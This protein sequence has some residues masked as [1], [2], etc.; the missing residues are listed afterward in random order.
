MFSK[1]SECSNSLLNPDLAAKKRRFAASAAG[2]LV[3]RVMKFKLPLL[4]LTSFVLGGCAT[5]CHQ[6]EFYKPSVENLG[7]YSSSW[8]NNRIYVDV[9]DGF[10][11]STFEC[12]TA[13][14]RV[15]GSPAAICLEIY[16]DEGLVLEFDDRVA[17]L[18]NELG[19]KIG[20]GHI[21]KEI[22]FVGE[23]NRSR[24]F[25]ERTLSKIE[26]WKRFYV[27]IS[28]PR[29]DAAE[30]FIEFPKT[31]VNGRITAIPRI[32]FQRTNEKICST[33]A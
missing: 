25:L 7:K 26:G 22:K 24:S 8:T 27:S 21:E 33:V 12:G 10:T 2:R 28:L 17:V 16:L 29:V 18:M 1:L 19:Q 23:K 5:K 15:D 14:R 3:Q 11:F 9:G 20:T 30:F 13:Y 6:E 31:L 4:I 32:R